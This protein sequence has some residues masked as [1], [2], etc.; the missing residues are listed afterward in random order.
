MTSFIAPPIPPVHFAEIDDSGD[1][2]ELSVEIDD[3]YQDNTY[4]HDQ[5]DDDFD[6]YPPS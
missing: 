6:P 3:I 1:N 5:H 4:D 2:D